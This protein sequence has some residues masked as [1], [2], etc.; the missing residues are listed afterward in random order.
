MAA[1]GA[2]RLMPMVQNAVAVIGIE[3]LAAKRKVAISMHRSHRAY[4]SNVCARCCAAKWRILT[5][6]DSLT[7]TYRE[8][9]NWYV[10]ARLQPPP[11]T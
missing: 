9:S 1:H 5:I 8:R 7:L 2:S 3:L 10:M 6:I 4:R 11:E